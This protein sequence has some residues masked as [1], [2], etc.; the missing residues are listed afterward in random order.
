MRKIDRRE[1]ILTFQFLNGEGKCKFA[2]NFFRAFSHVSRAPGAIN[3]NAAELLLTF[4]CRIMECCYFLSIVTLRMTGLCTVCWISSGRPVTYHL[5]I[6][7]GFSIIENPHSQSFSQNKWLGA[8]ILQKM[9]W[10][11]MPN[12]YPWPI[13]RRGAIA[14]SDL[15]LRNGDS[16]AIWARNRR[17][18]LTGG[19]LMNDWNIVWCISCVSRLIPASWEQGR[20]WELKFWTCCKYGIAWVALCASC[21]MLVVGL[22]IKMILMI[23]VFIFLCDI[24]AGTRN[25]MVEAQYYLVAIGLGQFW[26]PHKAH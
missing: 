9:C 7:I 13:L 19:Q 1:R 12:P 11:R 4:M 14:R 25:W 16:A 5:D 2:P 17:F 23:R 6:K 24:G 10:G 26:M 22:C 21:G 15:I 3:S 18:K 8:E 20:E